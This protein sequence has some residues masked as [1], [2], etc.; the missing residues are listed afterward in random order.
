MSN[1]SISNDGAVALAQ[2]LH[3]N[4]RLV[5][6]WLNGNNAITE[7]GTHALIE[8]LNMSINNA[9]R[10]IITLVLPTSC[11]QYATQCPQ[12]DKVKEKLCFI[13]TTQYKLE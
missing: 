7:E 6:L 8:A 10:H 12:Y 11:E 5:I 9:R 1:N 3:H 2:A 13:E 4:S